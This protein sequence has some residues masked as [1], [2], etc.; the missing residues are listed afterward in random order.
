LHSV[1]SIS[2]PNSTTCVVKNALLKILGCSSSIGCLSCNFVS[3]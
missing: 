1:Q 2:L 3:Y